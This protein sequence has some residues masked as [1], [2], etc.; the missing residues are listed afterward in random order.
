MSGSLLVLDQLAAAQSICY[1]ASG[2]NLAGARSP[3]GDRGWAPYF[4]GS[5]DDDCVGLE[6]EAGVEGKGLAIP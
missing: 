3:A 1:L 4:I 5:G 6:P 2:H